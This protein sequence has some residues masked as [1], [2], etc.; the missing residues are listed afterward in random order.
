[1]TRPLFLAILL[2]DAD[3]VKLL[4]SYGACLNVEVQ[5]VGTSVMSFALSK[6][7]SDVDRVLLEYRARMKADLLAFLI[8]K[9]QGEIIDIALDFG[10]EINKPVGI[11]ISLV[12][13]ALG[14]DEVD[15]AKIFLK[16]IVKREN[17]NLFVSENDFLSVNDTDKLS[18]FVEECELELTSMRNE[19]VK[20]TFIAVFDLLN[21]RD[22][23]KLASYTRNEDALKL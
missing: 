23:V 6:G 17:Q 13:V 15:I 9:K 20:G 11:D 1:M 4:V 14:R 10:V 21:T 12:T 19:F 16:P 7:K 18:E 8:Y 2:G 5:V 3:I 22:I